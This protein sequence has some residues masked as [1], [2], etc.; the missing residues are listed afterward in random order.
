[1]TTLPAFSWNRST[2]VFWHPL[3]CLCCRSFHISSIKFLIKRLD[4][5]RQNSSSSATITSSSPTLQFSTLSS[6]YADVTSPPDSTYD[7]QLPSTVTLPSVQTFK[8]RCMTHLSLHRTWRARRVINSYGTTTPSHFPNII[9]ER[10]RERSRL[11][12]LILVTRWAPN[13]LIF[14]LSVVIVWWSRCWRRRL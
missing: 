11:L 12:L 7:R 3:E 10:A 13:H 9:I 1:M 6:I 14:E 5:Y 8:K 2:A 4:P